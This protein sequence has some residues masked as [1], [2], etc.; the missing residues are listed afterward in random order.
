MPWA[1]KATGDPTAG[2]HTQE[3][4]TSCLEGWEQ[5]NRDHRKLPSFWET[6]SKEWSSFSAAKPGW[7]MVKA[8]PCGRGQYCLCGGRSVA[9][10]FYEGDGVVVESKISKLFED[11][12]SSSTMGPPSTPGKGSG[13]LDF[14]DFSTQA[15]PSTMRPG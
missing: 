11:H 6:H 10:G 13:T 4:E 15:Q 1:H 5:E 14:S 3:A 7:V 2:F 8:G 12:F 9:V